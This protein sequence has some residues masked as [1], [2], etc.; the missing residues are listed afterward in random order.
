MKYFLNKRSLPECG[1]L[2]HEE[3][4][5]FL[6]EEND[7]LYLGNYNSGH[8]A[9]SAARKI[10]PKA[11]LCYYCNGTHQNVQKHPDEI[12]LYLINLFFSFSKN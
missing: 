6:P 4:C 9:I 5:P 11:N 12:Q 3:N 7:R 8:D 10:I 2:V 1:Y